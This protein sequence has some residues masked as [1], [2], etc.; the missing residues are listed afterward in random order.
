LLQGVGY[1][2]NLK[3]NTYEWYLP[4]LV[5]KA[6]DQNW[7]EPPKFPGLTNAYFQALEIGKD[8]FLRPLAGDWP[9][10]VQ[11]TI[12]GLSVP[13]APAGTVRQ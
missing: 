11:P 8:S 10:S 13:S 4:V 6:A 2:V 3:N 7:D 12:I 5:T 9:S 1:I